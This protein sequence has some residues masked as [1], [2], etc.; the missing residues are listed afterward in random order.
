MAGLGRGGEEREGG[1][2]K[3]EEGSVCHADRVREGGQASKPAPKPNPSPRP[4]SG[5]RLGGDVE[6]EPAGFKSTTN[7]NRLQSPF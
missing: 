7:E 6:A 2:Y 5:R 1:L 3:G 4:Q